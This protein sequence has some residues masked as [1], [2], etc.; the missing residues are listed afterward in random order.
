MG[1]IVYFI[2]K[3]ILH[4]WSSLV[5]IDVDHKYFYSVPIIRTIHLFPRPHLSPVFQTSLFQIHDHSISPLATVHYS[6]TYMVRPFFLLECLCAT[7]LGISLHPCFQG[8]LWEIAPIWLIQS[9]VLLIC[10]PWT[11]PYHIITFKISV[12]LIK[13]KEH[14]TT[15]LIHKPT[16]ALPLN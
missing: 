11:Y 3:C 9:P 13:C 12:R 6:N 16:P 10:M 15:T 7:I 4:R 8:Q 5:H 2:I 14:N 1:Q